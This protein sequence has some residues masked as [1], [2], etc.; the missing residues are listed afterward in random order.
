MT[1]SMSDAREMGW[2]ISVEGVSMM[3]EGFGEGVSVGILA[4]LLMGV[5]FL[6]GVSFTGVSAG[7]GF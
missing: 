5:S 7:W 6:T 4:S 2:G 3:E 1:G